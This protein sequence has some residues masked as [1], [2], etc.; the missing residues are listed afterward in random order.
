MGPNVF[1]C[2]TR[3]PGYEH[4]QFFLWYGVGLVL[5]A[6]VAFVAARDERLSNQI[7]LGLTAIVIWAL[8]GLFAVS[9]M[10]T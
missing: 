9:A 1:L 10:S 2:V 8:Y 6:P 4:W 7:G 3:F 5:W